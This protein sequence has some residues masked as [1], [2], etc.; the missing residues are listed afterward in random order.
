[1]ADGESKGMVLVGLPVLK[2]F[3]EGLFRGKVT[4]Y[5]EKYGYYKVVYEDGDVEELE[6]LELRSILQ[7]QSASTQVAGRGRKS[8]NG[9]LKR[10]T[11]AGED[12]EAVSAA[13]HSSGATVH[14]PADA[15]LKRRRRG[16]KDR[17]NEVGPKQ[18]KRKGKRRR[19]GEA[20][21]GQATDMNLSLE[22]VFNFARGALSGNLGEHSPTPNQEVSGSEILGKLPGDFEQTPVQLGGKEG[23]NPEDSEKGIRLFVLALPCLKNQSSEMASPSIQQQHQKSGRGKHDILSTPTL[24]G[25]KRNLTRKTRGKIADSPGQGRPRPKSAAAKSV[26][27]R[28]RRN[29]KQA[30]EGGSD[31]E[32]EEGESRSSSEQDNSEETESDSESDSDEERSRTGPNE[33]PV[34][35]PVPVVATD[36][37]SDPEVGSPPHLP[38]RPATPPPPPLP[39]LPHS[40]PDLPLPAE[41]T[42]EAL[43]ILRFCTTFS[44]QLFLSPFS[45]EDLCHS[46]QS[47]SPSHLLTAVHL[48]LIR[49]LEEKAA[50]QETPLA[51]CLRSV[52]PGSDSTVHGSCAYHTCGYLYLYL[53]C[54]YCTNRQITAND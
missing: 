7:T 14:L 27:K 3:A 43:V 40:S 51:S 15:T 4:N 32:S 49:P 12:P 13:V 35:M 53:L 1:M 50:N 17:G 33:E 45:L 18:E 37:D 39:P 48:A 11:T 21:Q 28:I 52:R 29:F 22:S 5:D 8:A 46:L 47:G 19:V 2:V 6:W 38:Q 23:V 44:R 24:S 26:T 31:T 20:A 36:P 42:V 16:N 34:S 54:G 10:Q 9:K 30:K 25:R 41:E